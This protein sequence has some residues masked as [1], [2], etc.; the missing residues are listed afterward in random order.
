MVENAILENHKKYCER[1]ELYKSFGYDVE[2]ERSFI[3][4]K[5]QPLYGDIVEIGTGKGYFTIALAK[6][7]YTFVSVDIS[8]DEQKFAR[9]NLVYLGLDKQIDFEVEDAGH[10][11]FDNKSFDIIFAINILHHLL[12]PFKVINELIRIVSFEGKIILSDFSEEGFEMV[13]KIHAREGRIHYRNVID[14]NDI[15]GYFLRKDFKIEQYN[16]RFQNIL[17]ASHQFF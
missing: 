10:V 15:K 4:E 3:I 17:I 11:S 6:Q 8:E 16:S 7:G 14:L 1:I 2:E 5:A 13:D 12:S 9:Q